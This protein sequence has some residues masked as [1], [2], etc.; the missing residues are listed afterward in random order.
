MDVSEAIETRRTCRRFLDKPVP[1][2]IIEEILEKAMRS[3]S[4]GNLQPW[5]V[6]VVAGDVRDQ[7]VREVKEF[8]SEGQF[9]LIKGAEYKVYPPNLKEPYRTRRYQVGEALYHTLG[10]PREDKEARLKWFTG[11]NYEFFGART[12]F[13][14]TM[15]RIM[16]E[17]QWA[18]LGMFMQSIM[19]LAREYGL[20]TAPQEAWASLAK[21]L[22][23]I[24]E[25]PDNEMLFC[26]MSIGYE[27]ISVP[28]AKF[29][30]E[31][32]PLSEVASFLGFDD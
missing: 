5:R 19:L 15:D 23:R 26:G 25:I 4:G 31:R 16:Q 2:E 30:S 27:D 20:H 32:A 24:L 9:N 12:G 14:F 6:Y 10:I 13:F 7:I 22:K 21:L 8:I 3:P 18:D 28:L 17:G 11:A 1:K 29:H